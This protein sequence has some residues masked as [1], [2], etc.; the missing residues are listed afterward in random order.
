MDHQ[1][2][3]D[4]EAPVV[5]EIIGGAVLVIAKLCK[6]DDDVRVGV[7]KAMAKRHFRK[8]PAAVSGGGWR[9]APLW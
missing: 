9:L 2:V 1:K 8:L 6:D 3:V 5:L 7:A 4:G